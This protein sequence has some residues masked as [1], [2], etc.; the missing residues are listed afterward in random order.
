MEHEKEVAS[1][2]ER[3]AC[4]GT[5]NVERKLYLVASPAVTSA[6]AANGLLPVWM[7]PASTE[8]AAPVAVW[9]DYPPS[10]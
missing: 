4:R 1:V 9:W 6:S 5:A 10:Y 2:P 7:E 3:N 8:R